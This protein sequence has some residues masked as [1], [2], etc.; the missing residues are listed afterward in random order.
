MPIFRGKDFVSAVSDYKDSVRVATRSNVNL[1]SLIF[2]VDDIVLVGKDRVLLA[3]QTNASQNGIYIWNAITSK[4]RRAPD[5]D[6]SHE[7]SAGVKVYVEEGTQNSQTN[8][9]LITPG[10][11]TIGATNL[12]FA[13]ENR[14]GN[15]EFSGTYGSASTSLVIVLDESGQITSVNAVDISIDGGEF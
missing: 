5:A 15:F 12:T 14:I 2:S 9:T 8:W 7:W 1:D 6:S 10:N 3:G 13:R 4:L 11:V